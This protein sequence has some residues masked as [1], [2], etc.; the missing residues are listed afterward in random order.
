VKAKPIT[1]DRQIGRLLAS[2]GLRSR[3]GLLTARRGKLKRILA[4]DSGR[5]VYATS[6]V[7]EEQLAAVLARHGLSVPVTATAALAGGPS[8]ID[9]EL[10]Q[11]V[12]EEHCRELLFSTLDW[13]DGE[14]SLEVGRPKLDDT[15]RVELDCLPLVLEYARQRPVRLDMVRI[16][17]GSTQGR[18]VA[19][20]EA[21]ALAE[22]A[23][24]DATQRLL[25]ERC[26][27]ESTVAQLVEASPA[28]AQATW[29]ALYGLVLLGAIDLE[30]GARKDVVS[31]A[32]L[33][34]RLSRAQDT[35]H[36]G[37]LEQA[38]GCTEDDVRTAYYG[39]ARR[40]HPDR[41]RS[42]EF[43][44]LLPAIETFFAKVTDA[45]NT[46]VD[47]NLREAY[48]EA[49]QAAGARKE[50][51][52]DRAYLA[53][54]NYL[55]A[56]GLIER[57]RLTDAVTSLENA[58]Q[59]DGGRAEY[60]LELGLL[61]ARNP[62]FRQ[63]AEIHLIEANRLDPTLVEGY[64]ALGNLYLKQQRGADA[65]RLFREV[66]RWEPGHLEARARLKELGERL[67]G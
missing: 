35:D 27:G 62:R 21:A 28:E 13:P 54:Q 20:A 64:L 44:D 26:D 14:A 51:E 61:L 32:E 59:L 10:L 48:D 11:P 23:E 60:R 31:R 1:V 30:T 17:I 8:A 3:S 41:L 39:L 66:L 6:N 18:P 34:A 29:R 7:V 56:R 40:Y 52:Q 16:R 36:Y 55:R 12:L 58:I 65:G 33:E 19:G 2:V 45:Y 67:S 53:R 25:L 49:R 57:G 15:P 47:R 38:P 50:P 5:V 9:A 22:A 43:A 24:L 46:L 37:I 63:Q 4:L 42:E